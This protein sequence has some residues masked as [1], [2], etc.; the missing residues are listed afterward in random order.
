MRARRVGVLGSGKTVHRYAEHLR[1]LG[2]EARPAEVLR[3]TPNAQ[4][5]DQAVAL[6][7][8]SQRVADSDRSSG[9]CQSAEPRL[10]LI[11]SSSVAVKMLHVALDATMAADHPSSTYDPS[12]TAVL[13]IKGCGTA[14]ACAACPA[15]TNVTFCGKQLRDIYAH[16]ESQPHL[17]GRVRTVILGV[18]T[19]GDRSYRTS[20]TLGSWIEELGVYETA[21]VTGATALVKQTLSWMG[22][23]GGDLVVTSSKSAAILARIIIEQC[24]QNESAVDTTRLS[25]LRL[26]AQGPS[27]AATLCGV[28]EGHIGVG[29]IEILT[30]AAPN[31][32]AIAELLCFGCDRHDVRPSPRLTTKRLATQCTS[33]FHGA[34]GEAIKIEHATEHSI[35]YII[36]VIG[37]SLAF[38]TLS[39]QESTGTLWPNI[40]PREYR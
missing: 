5:I 9:R 24:V 4:A 10:Q 35:L 31:I 19:G 33:I 14:S 15:F 26:V 40:W 12:R 8:G 22:A 16:L 38:A 32:E 34:T 29:T 18:A 17:H 28:L 21:E 3:F 6:I 20:T 27:T 39:R 1:R 30:P 11:L 36:G 23:S 25:N 37:L 7:L 13:T 2:A